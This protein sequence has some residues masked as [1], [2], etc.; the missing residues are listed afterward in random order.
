MD[1]GN[2]QQQ[3]QQKPSLR[4]RNTSAIACR[5]CSTSFGGHRGN[6]ISQCTPPPQTRSDCPA[7][8]GLNYEL[9]SVFAQTVFFFKKAFLYILI[10]SSFYSKNCIVSKKDG[11]KI[12]WKICTKDLFGSNC[13]VLKT[14]FFQT[15]LSF[16][17]K[18]N[19]LNMDFQKLI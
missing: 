1:K 10:F 12:W 17:S 9:N 4:K 16:G 2:K 7:L 6:I 11:S 8:F 18:W 5:I 3:Q 15:W 19:C 14:F 13:V